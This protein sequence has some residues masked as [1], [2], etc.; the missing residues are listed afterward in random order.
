MNHQNP[1]QKILEERKNLIPLA[2]T[3]GDRRVDQLVLAKKYKGV[4]ADAIRASN[5]LEI[6]EA[7]V[8]GSPVTGMIYSNANR[9]ALTAHGVRIPG[10]L[11]IPHVAGKIA[12]V[13]PDG[14]VLLELAD[15]Q[16]VVR[17]D[18]VVTGIRR[19]MGDLFIDIDAESIHDTATG[20]DSAVAAEE[21]LS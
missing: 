15:R 21:S 1:F 12:E 14:E 19:D 10:K 11:A 20:A 16:F 17:V 2:T 8:K 7:L 5:G 18:G 4:P 9:V 6:G 3:V 13:L